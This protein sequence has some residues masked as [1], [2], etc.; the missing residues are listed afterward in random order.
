MWTGLAC[1]PE[2]TPV[3]AILVFL[4]AFIFSFYIYVV[5]LIAWIKKKQKENWDKW[6]YIPFS[7]RLQYCEIIY[8]LETET[9]TSTCMTLYSFLSLSLSLS[10]SLSLSP[11]FTR[12]PCLCLSNYFAHNCLPIYVCIYVSINISISV[13][14]MY[15]C[16]Y[17]SIY[18][19]I[20]FYSLNPS[21]SN[22]LFK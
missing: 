7:N 5:H 18:L 19:S 10:F 11:P 14:C 20:L 3:S 17:V 9:E 13:I 21:I 4:L 12:S 8:P 22:M 15:V 16:M 6:Y 2:V 1:Q